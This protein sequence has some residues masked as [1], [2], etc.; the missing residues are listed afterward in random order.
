MN[1]T[2]VNLKIDPKTKM[3]AQLIAQE[4]GVPLSTL[5][6][7]YIKQLIRTKK[8]TFDVSE[9]PS[10]YL[11]KSLEEAEKDRKSGYVSPAFTNTNEAISWLD[12]PKRKYENQIRKKVR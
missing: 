6:K 4:I 10:E 2:I 5:L 9:E 8:V 7:S 11:I 1:Y 3:E 12:N